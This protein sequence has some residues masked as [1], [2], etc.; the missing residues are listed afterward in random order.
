MLGILENFTKFSVGLTGGIGSGKTAVSDWFAAQGVSI[1]DT[2]V[3]SHK[4]TAPN[5]AAIATIRK[6]LGNAFIDENG[7]LNRSYTREIVFNDET[8]R[9]RLQAILHPLIYQSC[10]KEAKAASGPYLMFVVPLLIESKE[11][12]SLMDRI[13]VV[14]APD[15]IRIARV[16]QRSQLTREQVQA[17]MSK[18][19]SRKAHLRIADHVLDNSSTKEALTLQLVQRHADYLAAS[20]QKNHDH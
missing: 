12:R 3:I 14:D 1:I 11:Y 18:Q 10:L 20:K 4:L 17:I 7:A 13:L 6:T 16:M 15:E 9:Q 2:D 8:T 5:G 19:A